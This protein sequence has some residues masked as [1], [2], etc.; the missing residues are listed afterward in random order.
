MWNRDVNTDMRIIE[1]T[2]K[3]KMYIFQ[4]IKLLGEAIYLKRKTLSLVTGHSYGT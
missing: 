3:Y 4:R 1:T 2:W